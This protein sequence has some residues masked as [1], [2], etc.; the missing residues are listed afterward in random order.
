LNLSNV[1]LNV[2]EIEETGGI[3]SSQEGL[4][5]DRPPG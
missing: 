2:V 5:V 1:E 3:L 4:A